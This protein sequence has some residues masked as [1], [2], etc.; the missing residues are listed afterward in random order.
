MRQPICS[1][2]QKA[3]NGR[4]AVQE[5]MSSS[6]TTERRRT[7]LSHRRELISHTLFDDFV[8]TRLT[9]CRLPSS[10][11]NGNKERE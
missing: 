1:D 5:V 11:L 9:K 4:V 10:R 6:K 2:R 8:F 3:Y 7:L